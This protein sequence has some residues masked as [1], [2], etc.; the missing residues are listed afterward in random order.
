MAEPLVPVM[1]VP[2]RAPIGGAPS[3]RVRRLPPAL[4]LAPAAPPPLD[5]AEGVP[6]STAPEL[7]PVVRNSRLIQLSDGTSVEPE[8]TTLARDV[9]QESLLGISTGVSGEGPG[10]EMGTRGVDLRRTVDKVMVSRLPALTEALQAQHPM[11]VPDEV[12]A[13]KKVEEEEKLTADITARFAESLEKYDV[14]KTD[15][16]KAYNAAR[17]M[18]FGPTDVIINTDPG[19]VHRAIESWAQGDDTGSAWDWVPEWAREPIAPLRGMVAGHDIA[20]TTPGGVKAYNEGMNWGGLNWLGNMSLLTLASQMY[21]AEGRGDWG[22]P[23]HLEN[24]RR[25]EDMFTLWDRLE[26]KADAPQAGPVQWGVG[27]VAKFTSMGIGQGLALMDK[28]LETT[29]FG[30][31]GVPFLDSSN[32]EAVEKAGDM[33]MSFGLALIDPDVVGT[34]TVGLGSKGVRRGAEKTDEAWRALR[35][36]YKT[37]FY[38]K[39]ADEAVAFVVGGVRSE[40]ELQDFME[41][42][43]TR[44]TSQLGPGMTEGTIDH[45]RNRTGLNTAFSTLVT[46]SRRNARHQAEARRQVLQQADA[47]QRAAAA[48][49][50]RGP[51]DP[52]ALKAQRVVAAQGR[53]DASEAYW[54]ALAARDSAART[55]GRARVT[56]GKA[57]EEGMSLAAPTIA[58]LE[59]TLRKAEGALVATRTQFEAAVEAHATMRWDEA[60]GKAAA[61]GKKVVVDDAAIKGVTVQA[62]ATYAA[63]VKTAKEENKAAKAAATATP[64]PVPAGTKATPRAMAKA[65]H[66]Q[67]DETL[68]EALAAAAKTR[69]EAIAAAR[70]ANTRKL[71]P[72]QEM[73]DYTVAAAKHVA[74]EALAADLAAVLHSVRIFKQSGK[75]ADDSADD[76]SA[77]FDGALRAFLAAQRGSPDDIAQASYNLSQAAAKAGKHSSNYVE[78]QLVKLLA[79]QLHVAKAAE[80]TLLVAA[81]KA[82][83][84]KI[85]MGPRLGAHRTMVRSLHKS[86]KDTAGHRGA[87]GLAVALQEIAGAYAALAGRTEASLTPAQKALVANIRRAEDLSSG[88]GM[89]TMSHGGLSQA[90]GGLAAATK[91]G[92]LLGFTDVSMRYVD[93]LLLP[94]RQYADPG[95]AAMGTDIDAVQQLV[96]GAENE[97]Y[98]EVAGVQKYTADSLD[99][100]VAE[101]KAAGLPPPDEAARKARRGKAI[102]E[103]MD[104]AG[105]A[106]SSEMRQAYNASPWER[107]APILRSVAKPGA[108]A[109]SNASETE[110]LFNGLAGSFLNT[111]EGSVA[112][113]ENQELA[114]Y[115]RKLLITPVSVSPEGDKVFITFGAFSEAMTKK[116][117]QVMN[118]AG[119]TPQVRDIALSARAVLQ[120]GA[121]NRLSEGVMSVAVDLPKQTLNALE[122]LGKN[123]SAGA[124]EYMEAAT[125]LADRLGLPTHI[126]QLT[127]DSGKTLQEGLVLLQDPANMDRFFMPRRW[128]QRMEKVSGEMTKTADMFAAAHPEDLAR[129]GA[130]AIS[131]ITKWWNAG[132]LSGVLLPSP[133]YFMSN[134][135]QGVSQVFVD[136]GAKQGFASLAQSPLDLLDGGVRHLP[137]IGEALHARV[138]RPMLLQ[139]DKFLPSMLGSMYT[140]SV[141]KFF[142]SDLGRPGET[143]GKSGITWAEMRRECIRQTV[144]QSSARAMG[145]QTLASRTEDARWLRAMGTWANAWADMSDAIDQRMRVSMYMNLRVNKGLSEEAAG[146][147][148]RDALYDW[149]HPLAEWEVKHVQ[150]LFMFWTWQRKAYGQA[151]RTALA[152]FSA[153]HRGKMFN[154]LTRTTRAHQAVQGVREMSA[155]YQQDEH[156]D[157]WANVSPF[158]LSETGSRI[159]MGATML[160]EEVRALNAKQGKAYTHAVYT[161][162]SPTQVETV[163]FLWSAL[164]TGAAM[165]AGRP[166]DAFDQGTKQLGQMLGPTGEMAMTEMRERG[167]FE[168]PFYSDDTT[169][170]GP[171]DKAMLGLVGATWKEGDV[172]KTTRGAMEIYKRVLTPLSVNLAGVL[173]P[174]ASELEVSR[175]LGHV[176]RQQTGVMREHPYSP[177]DVV[178]G[179]I[180]ETRERLRPQVLENYRERLKP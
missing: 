78:K 132:L 92:G 135:L 131:F 57:G 144:R 129:R 18:M 66:K 105:D 133:R 40:E 175:G 15:V 127:M 125:I 167:G 115:A 75:Q 4:S 152:P 2:T 101:H 70:V 77:A 3:P 6:V 164:G 29:T 9:S 48:V 76:V 158:W 71:V 39:A 37:D 104:A 25:G 86:A 23:E 123:D 149:A 97:L 169:V 19:R 47:D 13:A 58:T 62:K 108:V 35:Y 95:K 128:M 145:L 130:A 31:S 121:L 141:V 55:L 180:Q 45:V 111:R 12:F 64:P 80:D 117:A 160:P 28:V 34:V 38:N 33:V 1:P 81:G 107:A 56:A 59:E 50:S 120:A 118:M 73:L 98:Y 103:W 43:K 52:E 168:K 177:A 159:A 41:V 79:D 122:A 178:R 163:N 91:E 51:T 53:K 49:A 143:I 146:I 11:G 106:S 126:K 139:A 24:I 87:Q 136:M 85:K 21:G 94:F 20:V 10:A 89:R 113:K 151:F 109:S 138:V 157:K 171:F 16:N 27:N 156:D 72:Q 46:E 69:D 44:V 112:A 54:A 162:P 5:V 90:Y 74:E 88:A 165:A 176:L 61:Q 68:V 82:E 119:D 26:T 179:D 30:Q 63:A 84:A 99:A 173:N 14:D 7:P 154:P 174:V 60:V 114:R 42:L 150:S 96:K 8:Y 67:A 36:G 102:I 100:L 83:K 110:R 65:A 148:V 170:L 142:D 172:T 166:V 134:L 22:G 147:K 137:F 161:M 155:Q 124:E 116:A 153:E 32:P 17:G 93:A 140:P